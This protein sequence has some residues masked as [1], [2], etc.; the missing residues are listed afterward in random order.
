M[1]REITNLQVKVISNFQSKIAHTGLHFTLAYVPNPVS[2]Y[3]G[4]ISSLGK[5][6]ECSRNSITKFLNFCFKTMSVECFPSP[7]NMFILNI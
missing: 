2:E 4:Q 7:Q 6:D 3:P 1:N 5:S